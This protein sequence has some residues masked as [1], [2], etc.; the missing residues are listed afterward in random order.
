M[1]SQSPNPDKNP[2]WFYPALAIQT[3]VIIIVLGL[4]KDLFWIF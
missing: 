1:S 2:G 4:L 3:F